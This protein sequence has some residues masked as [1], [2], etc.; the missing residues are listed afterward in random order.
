VI[1]AISEA[2]AIV[3]RWSGI[4][5]LVRNTLARGKVSI[6]LYHS[7]SLEVLESHLD[8]LVRRYRIITLS[9]LVDA[10]HERNWDS[11]PGKAL[12]ITFDDGDRENFALLELFN[13][14]SVV[15]T[16]YL[17]S[18][19]VG[20]ARH[21]WFNEVEDPEPLKALPNA[22]RLAVLERRTGFAPTKEYAEDPQALSREQ[23]A[24][25]A[26]HVDFQSHTRFHPVLTT[27]SDAECRDEV[28]RSRIEVEELSG[29]EC[30]HF[31]Y[32]NGDY[33]LRER[34][35]VE[36][37]GYASGRTIDLG[38][39][40]INSDPYRLKI[41]SWRDDTSVS[42][43]AA[44]LTGIPGYLARL[45]RGSIRGRHRPVRSAPPA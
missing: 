44:D 4:P 21:Y 25:M 20:H 9:Q 36:Q 6:I 24:E 23:V 22:E 18:Q 17:C 37:A 19:I 32:P 16:I 35:L 5:F 3:L 31:S 33:G 27:C 1:R 26:G 34:V 42:R 13:R 28:E 38:W 45:R 39:N 14:Y 29:R 10:I 43:L 2:M 7:P 40:D 8:Y 30:R 41:L 15:P 12:V 11:V